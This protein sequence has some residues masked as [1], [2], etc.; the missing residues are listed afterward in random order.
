[1]RN[2]IDVRAVCI[3]IVTD[4]NHFER[5]TAIMLTN[6][7]SSFSFLRPGSRTLP[8]YH[9][10]LFLGLLALWKLS[11]SSGYL[12]AFFF[13]DPVKV[14]RTIA[15]WFSTGTIYRHLGVTLIETACAFFAGSVAGL[16]VGLWLA[17]NPLAAM[18]A[19][20]YVKAFNSMPRV[21]LAPIFAV[22]F[23]LGMTSKIAL[24]ITLVFFVVFFN[25]FQ[26]V[27]EVSQG[28]LA[29]ARML[30]A[31]PRQ[32]LKSVYLPSATSWLFSS[33]HT[34]VGMAF[35]GAVIGEYMGSEAGIGYLIL[36]AEGTFNINGVFAGVIILTF[37][38]IL[39]DALVSLVERKLLFWQHRE[40]T[41]VQGASL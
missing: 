36:E 30:G 17:L 21:I 35:V 15:G 13:G 24:G 4:T 28:I 20:P 12:S 23:G 41:T 5:K 40:T 10:A 38:A 2:V 9:L 8:I 33:L 25:V 14:F 27:R 37:F 18:L 31:G 39:L 26:G 32:L 1:M 7:R 16:G 34:A 6:S 11:T 3:V 22:W 19:S 29:N